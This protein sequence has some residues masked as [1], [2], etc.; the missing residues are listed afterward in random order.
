M[1]RKVLIVDDSKLARQFLSKLLSSLEPEWLRFE[2]AN[3]AETLEVAAREQ[4]EIAILDFNMPGKD[5]LALAAG[6]RALYPRLVVAI[7]TAN[8][9]DAV[10]NQAHAL[11]ALFVEK[12]VTARKLA[13]FREKVRTQLPD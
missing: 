4:P 5:G 9:Q 6:L 2:A 11:G 12:P 10:V 13:E 7:I 8:T 3:A 1:A